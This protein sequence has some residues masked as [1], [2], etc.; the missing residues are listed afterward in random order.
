MMPH[1]PHDNFARAH[2]NRAALSHMR[3][4]TAWALLGAALLLELAAEAVAFNVQLIHLSMPTMRSCAA[5]SLRLGGPWQQEPI[6]SRTGGPNTRLPSAFVEVDPERPTREEAKTK[7][8][9]QGIHPAADTDEPLLLLLG[10]ALLNEVLIPILQLPMVLT[11][12]GTRTLKRINDTMT[13][14]RYG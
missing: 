10:R 6:G 12:Q 14:E 9:E 3:M 2:S 13:V 7:A 4:P 1:R 11:N 8:R 5:V